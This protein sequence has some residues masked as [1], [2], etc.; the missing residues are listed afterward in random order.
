MQ[1]VTWAPGTNLEYDLLFNSLREKHF[2]DQNH[3]LWKN[4]STDAFLHSGIIACTIYFDADGIP[5]LCS[6]ISNRECWPATAYRMLNRMWKANNKK[7]FLRRISDCVGQSVIS[8]IK[9]LDNNTDYQLCFASRQTGYWDDWTL[10]SFK[11]DF[12]LIFKN[13][14]Y[15]YL[16]C[17]NECE[18]TCWQKI[19]YQGNEQILDQWKR[20]H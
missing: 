10:N 3:R 1:V 9:W 12:N 19:I 16:T 6:S 13:D 17:P 14:M 4:Y 15:K 18:D 5:E 8:Q 11:N 2:Q 20:R 7:S